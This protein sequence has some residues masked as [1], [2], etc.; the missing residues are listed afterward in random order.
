MKL[1]PLLNMNVIAEGIENEKQLKILTKMGCS[2]GQG[3]L[4]KDAITANEVES[5]L[6]N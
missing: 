4:F 1:G 6:E 2:Q 5:I 3:F